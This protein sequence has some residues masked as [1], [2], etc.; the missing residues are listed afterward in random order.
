[1]GLFDFLGKKKSDEPKRGEREIA[2][3]QKV[4][5]SKLS[6]NYDRQEAIEQLSRMATAES[7]AALLRRFDFTMDPSIT[8]QDEKDSA[9]KGIVAAGS[10]PA[11]ISAARQ[12]PNLWSWIVIERNPSGR[13]R[14][15]RSRADKLGD[16]AQSSDRSR[17]RAPC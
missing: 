11:V 14:R 17:R 2:R 6:Q 16:A 5:G 3:L 7:A 1:M 8:D 10:V 12:A 9:A 15:R 13:R 4:V